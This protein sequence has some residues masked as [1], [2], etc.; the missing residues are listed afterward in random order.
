[1]QRRYLAQR[2]DPTEAQG[3]GSGQAVVWV[4][5][6]LGSSTGMEL[7]NGVVQGTRAV[8]KQHAPVMRLWGDESPTIVRYG[9][10][11]LF[12]LTCDGDGR[13]AG[14]LVWGGRWQALAGWSLPL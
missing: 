11:I 2:R 13:A 3:Q 14:V 4:A 12:A 1:M 9:C 5:R 6:R 7:S 10:M 8:R